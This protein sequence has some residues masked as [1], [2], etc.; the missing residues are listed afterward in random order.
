MNEAVER[1][2]QLCRAFEGF[3][4]KPY[5]CPAGVPTIGY[6]TTFYPD[7]RKVTLQDAPI[8]KEQAEEY[9]KF[10]LL[11][12]APYVYSL[13]PVVLSDA[14]RAAALIDFSYN[15]GWPRLRASTLRK[16]VNEK[17]WAAAYDE[18]LKWNKAGG[19]VLQGLVLRRKAEAA[20]L[21]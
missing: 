7:K 3:F 2:A 5:I 1:A 4:A 17:D 12:I 8:S 18:I 6:G 10:E 19:K 13:C 15:L 9:M 11:G 20:L 16:R 21:K 14:R